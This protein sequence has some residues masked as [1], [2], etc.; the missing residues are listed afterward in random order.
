MDG[1][2][3]DSDEPEEDAR[4]LEVVAYSSGELEVGVEVET[5]ENRKAIQFYFEVGVDLETSFPWMVVRADRKASTL[6]LSRT[7]RICSSSSIQQ[8]R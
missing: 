1:K 6:R 4:S 7:G 2:I 5:F 3:L 8:R